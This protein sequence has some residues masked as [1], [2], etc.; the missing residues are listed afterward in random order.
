MQTRPIYG[1]LAEFETPEQVLE[2]AQRTHD[3]GYK[4]IDAFSPIP[5]HGLAEA[6]GFD[7]TSLPIIVF[8]GGLCGGLTG[9]GMCYYANVVSYAWK[10]AASPT[11]AG[12]SWIPITFELTILG[13][14]S[15]AVLGMLAMNGSRRRI[16]RCLTCRASPW[17]RPTVFSVHQGAR[18]K[19]RS[20]A[21]Q[22]A[23]W[24][25]CSRMESSKLRT[26]FASR[27]GISDGCAR[28]AGSRAGA[29]G[30]LA[31]R[32]RRRDAALRLSPG[33]APPA[34]ILC[35]TS[36]PA[37]F[38]TAAPSARGSRN[39]RSRPVAHR[40]LFYTGKDQ[41]RRKP[42]RFPFPI[43]RADLERG[44]QSASIFIA[45]RAMTIRAPEMA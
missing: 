19:I 44:P 21:D 43:T 2:A 39:R 25:A 15:S 40:R 3:A 13:A 10:S 37:S 8:I 17:R 45:R 4:R 38:R 9:F 1:M 18:P 34:E 33:H 28:R 22:S 36:H 12:R 11:I 31:S 6:V 41:W 20:N 16:I 32:R 26:E 35:R 5:V 27:L 24:K 7:W 30:R 14:A 42:T 29:R 23:F